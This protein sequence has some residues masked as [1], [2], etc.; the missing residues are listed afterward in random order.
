MIEIPPIR[1]DTAAVSVPGSKS[2]THRI[3]IAASL[4]DGLCTVT[5]ALKSEDT[6]L[7]QN[8]LRQM[9]VMIEEKNASVN[10]H[11]TGGQLKPA[12]K[13]ICLANS[14]TSMRLL[15][16]VAAIG[17]GEYELTGTRRMKERPIQ[18]LLDA[19][20]LLGVD[21]HSKNDDGCPPVIVRGGDVMGGRTRVRCLLSSQF[22]SALLLIA[23]YT[24]S[25]M[26]ID[27]TEGPVSR[28][29]IDMTVDIMGQ[30]GVEVRRYGYDR[31]DVAGG[32]IY[33]S[34][35]YEV[36]PDYSQA[37]YFWGAAAVSGTAVKVI[38]T[39]RN[40]RQGDV[41]FLE[42]LQKMGCKV[43]GEPDGITVIGR[44]LS[45]IEVDM[46][47]MPDMVPTLAVV[48][49]FACG[50]TRIKGVAHLR[51]KES[52]RI[53]SVVTELEKLGID[54]QALDDG[55]LI[56]GG[57]PRGTRIDTY[58]DHRMA[59][60]FSLAGLMVPGVFINDETCV[61]K[62]FPDYWEVL[63]KLC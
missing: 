44:P 63:K 50:V 45:G 56:Q 12:G 20:R 42:V 1:I 29:Y 4:S 37:G 14:G 7:T 13:P 51:A 43:I 30:M 15:T 31:F 16:G 55:M 2:Y 49:A 24:A 39:T 32:R 53:H 35:D 48:A 9:G 27:V 19:L 41:R 58:N 10:I 61:R 18:D 6:D 17:R 11:G 25:G 21:A 22:L 33:A 3:L 57:T 46:A 38:R 23:P 40:T 52:D 26:T 28:P 62:S 54:A 34:G 5:G 60:A 47:D 36:E 59:M 8:G